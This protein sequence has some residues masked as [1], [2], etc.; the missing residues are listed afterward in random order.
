MTKKNALVLRFEEFSLS[1]ALLALTSVVA[2]TQQETLG[3]NVEEKC[4]L[5]NMP[6]VEKC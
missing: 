3:R 6:E 4:I 2:L 5:K 1:P